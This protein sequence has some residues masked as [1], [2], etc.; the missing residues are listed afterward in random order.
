MAGFISKAWADDIKN[1]FTLHRS[2]GFVCSSC[3][4][5]FKSGA[6][7]VGG[8]RWRKICVQCFLKTDF[9]KNEKETYENVADMLNHI[10]L[11][12]TMCEDEMI[13]AKDLIAQL[14]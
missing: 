9:Q 2:L 14:K 8:G 6:H 12:K 7:Y 5:E 10:Y 11:T 1:C 4:T 3:R 13:G